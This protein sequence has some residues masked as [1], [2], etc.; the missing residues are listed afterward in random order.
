MWREMGLG[1]TMVLSDSG[2]SD[3]SVTGKGLVGAVGVGE[4]ERKHA[5][6][7]PLTAGLSSSSSIAVAQRG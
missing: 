2:A 5:I 4:S 3:G 1:M 6:M 7:T